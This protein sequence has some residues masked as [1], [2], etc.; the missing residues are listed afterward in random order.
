MSIQQ[1]Q[2]GKFVKYWEYETPTVIRTEKNELR[3]FAQH[4]KV[5][6]YPIVEG[7]AHGIGKGATIN[8]DTFTKDELAQFRSKLV[9]LVN[10]GVTGYSSEKKYWEHEEPVIISSEKNEIR[11]YCNHGKLQVFPKIETG[12]GIGRGATLNLE[13]IDYS[14]IKR[15]FSSFIDIINKFMHIPDFDRVESNEVPPTPQNKVQEPQAKQEGKS[16]Q[17]LLFE[18]LQKADDSLIQKLLSLVGENQADEEKPKAEKVTEPVSQEDDIKIRMAQERARFAQMTDDEVIAYGVDYYLKSYVEQISELYKEQG[19]DYVIKFLKERIGKTLHGWAHFGIMG[20]SNTK[21]IT[22]SNDDGRKFKLSWNQVL[23]KF[24]ELHPEL[25]EVN[26]SVEAVEE[27]LED[28]SEHEED[29]SEF[30][31]DL[32]APFVEDETENEVEETKSSKEFESL[33]DKVAHMSNEQLKEE[34]NANVSVA[35]E[36][37]NPHYTVALFEEMKKRQRA[38]LI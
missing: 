25:F 29:F 13:G 21:G 38:G 22:L 34:Y 12:R 6:V 36:K 26:D 30:D 27:E 8:F 16:K 23:D 19:Y 4:G 14:E 11:F 3:I 32:E 10:R 1:T 35:E 33:Q 24:M 20:D 31:E 17:E 2:K 15:I 9:N 28:F 7:T 5:Q 18:L 37:F